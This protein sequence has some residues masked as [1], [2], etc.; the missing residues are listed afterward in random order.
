MKNLLRGL[1]LG[2]IIG[3]IYGAVMTERRYK[4]EAQEKEDAFFKL[5]EVIESM[6]EDERLQR[7]NQWINDIEEDLDG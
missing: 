5:P 6:K 2:W 3:M 7:A 1:L 4:R